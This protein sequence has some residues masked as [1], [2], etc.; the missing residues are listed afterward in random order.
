MWICCQESLSCFRPKICQLFPVPVQIPG[1]GAVLLW[2]RAAA[3]QANKPIKTTTRAVSVDPGEA[4]QA[5]QPCWQH[6]LRVWLCQQTQ[7]PMQREASLWWPPTAAPQAALTA[8]K[9]IKPQAVL[10][11]PFQLACLGTS[12]ITSKG[13][14]IIF[15]TAN[16]SA[17]AHKTA[18]SGWSSYIW[19]ITTRLILMTDWTLF[20]SLTNL[21]TLPLFWALP[22]I[23]FFLLL[24]PLTLCSEIPSV[25]WVDATRRLSLSLGCSWASVSVFCLQR[26]ESGL[27]G[28]APAVRS[29]RSSR[30]AGVTCWRFTHSLKDRQQVRNYGTSLIV[31]F[32]LFIPLSSLN[33]PDCG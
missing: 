1:P 16:P 12:Q 17:E 30:A 22:I 32:L 13:E 21:T 3:T 14:S 10:P 15:P 20:S 6:F 33:R 24:Y 28:K 29:S 8:R 11:I 19:P 23:F 5:A 2:T 18:A 27:S 25:L 26:G 7:P 31:S 9:T 4:S